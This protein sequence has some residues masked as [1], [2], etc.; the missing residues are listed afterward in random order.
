MLYLEERAVI[1]ATRE[2]GPPHYHIAVFPQDYALYVNR[3]T[4]RNDSRI[5]QTPSNTS[6]TVRRRDTLWRIAR[7]H[8][9]TVDLI[10]RVNQLRSAVIHPGQVLRIPATLSVN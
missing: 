3:I 10:R 4:T 9:T 7:Q 5:G 8:E 2:R 1:E 6:Y